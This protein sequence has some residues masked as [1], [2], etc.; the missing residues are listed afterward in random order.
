MRLNIFLCSMN[1]T[2]VPDLARCNRRNSENP[3]VTWLRNTNSIQV[4]TN[5]ASNTAD[6]R[7][8]INFLLIL[9]KKLQGFILFS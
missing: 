5:Q 9:R 1:K 4:C 2:R 6:S 8:L 7:Y 3:C